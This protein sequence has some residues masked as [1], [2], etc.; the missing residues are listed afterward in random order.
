MRMKATGRR[1]TAAELE[2][3]C[4]LHGRGFRYRV[5]YAPIAN[6]RFRADVVFT[7]VKMAIFIDGCYWHGC[8]IHGTWPKANGA[9]WRDKIEANRARDSRIDQTL[10]T[11]GWSVLRIWEHEEPVQAVERVLAFLARSA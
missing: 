3:R 10:K 4:L 11:A 8:P 6:E 5:D 9:W 2:I 7:R 1:D